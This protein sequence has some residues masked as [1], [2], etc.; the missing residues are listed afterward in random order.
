[1][2]DKARVSLLAGVL[3]TFIGCRTHESPTVPT[4]A[5]SPDRATSLR[6]FGVCD[7]ENTPSAPALP[8]LD[9]YFD[10]SKSMKGYVVPPDSAYRRVAQRLL[11][12]SAAAGYEQRVFRFSTTTAQE[13]VRTI[14]KVLSPSF[15]DGKD[16]PLAEFVSAIGPADANSVRVLVTDLVQSEHGKDALALTTAFRRLAARTPRVALYGFRS[17]FRGVYYIESGKRGTLDLDLDDVHG[18]PFFILVIAPNDQL[19]GQF[20]RFAGV[21][22]L[23]TGVH[24]PDVQHEEF[25]PSISPVIVKTVKLVADTDFQWGRFDTEDSWS[26]SSLSFVHL[27]SLIK[28]HD[29][30]NQVRDLMFSIDAEPNAS[31]LS[32][33]R[34]D[35][36]ITKATHSKVL[37]VTAAPGSSAQVKGALGSVKCLIRYHLPLPEPNSWEIYHVT[38]KVGEANLLAPPWTDDWSTSNDQLR[39]NSGRALNLAAIVES[40]LRSVSENVVFLDQIIELRREES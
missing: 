21:L 37:S 22:A 9:V 11:Q 3:L 17:A 33:S 5:P 2:D 26:C 8:H 35:V 1:M 19:L 10:N 30:P 34:Y 29:S 23:A 24:G 31:V 16:T 14:E 4:P 36:D 15:Y 20:E 7:R 27:T 6:L 32:P 38:V 25:H 40:M 18:R 12:K 13:P 39:T 28:R